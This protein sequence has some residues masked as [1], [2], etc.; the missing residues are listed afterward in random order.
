MDRPPNNSDPPSDSRLESEPDWPE[1]VAAA[2]GFIWS[3]ET[4]LPTG[5][6][7]WSVQ[8]A[9]PGVEKGLPLRIHLARL[10][11]DLIETAILALLIFLPVRAMVQ[12]FRVDGSS[13]EGSLH[14]GQY[15]LVNKAVYFKVNLKFL[16]FLPF[17]D[18]SSDQYVFR[19]PRRGDVIVF[20]FP[21]GP[22][23]DFIKRIIGEPGD[24]VQVR[25]GLVFINGKAL[26]ENYTSN[27]PQYDYGPQEV[28]PGQ[29][30]VL[31]DNRNNSFDSHSWGMVPQENII[32][33]AW[34]SYWPFS[35]FGLV[36]DPA[37][38]PMGSQEESP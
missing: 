13:M 8:E 34:L 29:Y 10:A 23:R 28:P 36:S 5:L 1:G 4:T 19:A 18:F 37:I 3:T 11:R 21:G 14:N 20:R 24:I 35:E 26:D 9:F 27:R 22:S 6:A 25:D 12:N 2:Q 16:D 32:G 7:P 17:V 31:G 15:I 38:Q 33:R 30:F